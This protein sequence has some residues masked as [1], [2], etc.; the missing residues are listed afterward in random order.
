MKI[1]KLLMLLLLTPIAALA[2]NEYDLL[3]N[4]PQEVDMYTALF[5]GIHYF[6]HGTTGDNY[7]SLLRTIVL[8]GTMMTMIKSASAIAGGASGSGAVGASSL[9]GVAAYQVFVV[10][11]LST[12]FAR[13]SQLIIK[14]PQS[15][16]FDVSAT[17]PDVFGFTV[18]FFSNLNYKMTAIAESSF[19]DIRDQSSG[20]IY[21]IN[22][23]GQNIGYGMTGLGYGGLSTILADADKA[24]LEDMVSKTGESITQMYRAYIKDCVIMPLSISQPTYTSILLNKPNLWAN[25]AP[26]EMQTVTGFAASSMLVNYAGNIQPCDTL[27]TDMNAL[28]TDVEANLEKRHGEKLAGLYYANYFMQ[29][30]FSGGSF[31]S[32]A[33]TTSLIKDASYTKAQLMDSAMA[34]DYK[35]IFRELGQSGNVFASGAGS[36]VA[37]IQQNGLGNGAFMSKFLPVFSSFIFMIMI[38]SFPFMFAFALMPGGFTIMVQFMKTLAWVSLWS[39]MAAILNFFIDYRM[40][41]QVKEVAFYEDNSI[42]IEDI[43]P[44]PQM[45]DLSSEAAT[46]AGL[47]GFLY[48]MVPGL[49]WMLVTG[50]GVMLSNI[51]GSLGGAFQKNSSS[52][53]VQDKANV[54]GAAG[55]DKTVAAEQDFYAAGA[56]MAQTQAAYEGQ[57]ATYGDDFGAMATDQGKQ[58]A[59]QHGTTQGASSQMTISQAAAGG[60]AQGKMSGAS[61][62]A[63][64]EIGSAMSN[65][66]L[67]NFGVQSAVNQVSATTTSEENIKLQ[68]GKSGTMANAEA[69][70]RLEGANAQSIG[71]SVRA[72]EDANN[73]SLHNYAEGGAISQS[74]KMGEQSGLGKNGPSTSEATSAGETTGAIEGKAQKKE[75]KELD[76]FTESDTDKLGSVQGTLKVADHKAVLNAKKQGANGLESVGADE[77]SQVIETMATSKIESSAATVR[78]AGGEEKYKASQRGK[79]LRG[80]SKDV[81]EFTQYDKMSQSRAAS[82][83]DHESKVSGEQNAVNTFDNT[84]NRD[85]SIKAGANAYNKK[86][87]E[88]QSKNSEGGSE[89]TAEEQAEMDESFI[90]GYNE[91]ASSRNKLNKGLAKSVAMKKSIARKAQANKINAEADVREQAVEAEQAVLDQDIE[92]AHEA[93]QQGK[94]VIPDGFKSRDAK[95]QARQEA[96]DKKMAGVNSLREKAQNTYSSM[97][98]SSKIEEDTR[99]VMAAQVVQANKMS[100]RNIEAGAVDQKINQLAQMSGTHQAVEQHGGHAVANGAMVGSAQQAISQVQSAAIFNNNA[101]AA[102]TFQ[103]AGMI[104]SS[105]VARHTGMSMQSMA[106]QGQEKKIGQTAGEM[107]RSGATMEQLHNT[108]EAEGSIRANYDA[109]VGGFS[110]NAGGSSMMQLGLASG[111]GSAGVVKTHIGGENLSVGG[112]TKVWSSEE[113]INDKSHINRDVVNRVINQYA[114]TYEDK[115]FVANLKGSVKA[116]TNTAKSFFTGKRLVK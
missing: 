105:N 83:A 86:K 100:K 114:T 65:A 104:A 23:Y 24:N 75:A 109:A 41:Q 25:I 60:Q 79:G 85:A 107:Q 55:G 112:N 18:S 94:S 68:G 113:G 95:F 48:L 111:T 36:S 99:A 53:A 9:L 33:T 20:Q 35:G 52:E 4:T 7:L 61:T 102:A 70:A 16:T 78:G 6:F 57:K 30:D 34:N 80:G 21:D 44:N 71:K 22:S 108:I 27:Y 11:M 97:N 38:A 15:L 103:N 101:G 116:G 28:K 106:I 19:S 17:I 1:F 46:M 14:H 3:V 84:Q 90:D 49:S 39:P 72:N 69:L 64:G 63:M 13:E 42:V 62:R 98:E 92:E 67:Q 96:I 88:A 89:I 110:S 32:V 8:F 115:K 59:Q 2:L 12:L 74:R 5:D 43:L 77:Q 58:V 54:M 73:G 45:I 47:A 50:S 51:T 26:S 81:A 82:Q 10:F 29:G 40:M 31:G 87:K 91:I 37:E 56:K 93:V 66:G 76:S